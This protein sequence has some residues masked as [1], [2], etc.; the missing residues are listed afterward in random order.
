MM[1]NDGDEQMNMR[2]FPEIAKL[3]NELRLPEDMLLYE[4]VKL[5]ARH[6]GYPIPILPTDQ[7]EPSMTSLEYW[8]QDN[9]NGKHKGQEK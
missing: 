6:V 8:I 7:I 9:Y 2:N 4:G 5:I 3:W 1:K